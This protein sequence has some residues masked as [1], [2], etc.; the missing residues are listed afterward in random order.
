MGKNVPRLAGDECEC[1][2]L[3][4]R[5]VDEVLTRREG[6]SQVTF[7]PFH[8]LIN[9]AIDFSLPCRASTLSL[10]KIVFLELFLSY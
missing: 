2:A 4:L 1:L 3:G 7:S 10:L 9:C 8:T 5:E 6:E